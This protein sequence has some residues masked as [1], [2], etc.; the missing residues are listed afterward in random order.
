MKKFSKTV[1]LFISPAIFLALFVV[2]LFLFGASQ[3]QAAYY[4]VD[5]TNGNDSNNGQSCSAAEKTIAAGLAETT[6]AGDTLIIM[7]GT[8]VESIYPT[9][10]NGSAGL[11]I[12]IRSATQADVD[13]NRITS[14]CGGASRIGNVTLNFSGLSA[15]GIGAGTTAS[16]ITFSGF[17]V[18]DVSSASYSS[19]KTGTSANNIIFDHIT[20]ND[21]RFPFQAVSTSNAVTVQYCTFNGSTASGV[22]I[23][24]P[25]TGQLYSVDMVE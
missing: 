14:G 19:L 5:G 17:T 12:T 8:Y 11:P 4:Y 24:Y 21:S 3:A 15:N 9:T 16:Y 18:G 20:V 22:P 2:G 10:I 25:S 7:S 1:I 23:M 13:A 6:A